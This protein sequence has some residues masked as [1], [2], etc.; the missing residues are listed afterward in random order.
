VREDFA[1]AVEIFASKT[2]VPEDKILNAIVK[3]LT[4]AYK[5]MTK[6]DNVVIELDTISKNLKIYS[7]KTVKD[8]VEDPIT[9]ISL[10]EAQKRNPDAR[11]D[12]EILDEIDPASMG[13]IAAQISQQVILEDIH[14]VEQDLIYDEFSAKLGTI[15]TG[16]Y[17]R[18][19]KKEDIIVDLAKVEGLLP[20]EKQLPK[21]RLKLGEKV[22][23]YIKNV[24]KVNNHIRIILSRTDPDFVKKLFELE[25]PELASNVVQIKGIARDPGERSKVAV[26]SEQSDIDPVGSCV[27]MKGVRI[28]SVIREL[29]GEKIDIV[30]WD[31]NTEKYIQNL[32]SPVKILNVKLNHEEKISIV[33]VPPDQ[34][35]SAIGKDG[36]N[37]RLA[38]ILLG[39]TID[40]KSEDDFQR[41]L[42]AE[43]S[44]KKIKEL[45]QEPADEEK[46]QKHKKKATTARK[47]QLKEVSA[48][49]EEEIEETSIEE[50]P[51]VPQIVI[52]K[53]Q[54]A[55]YNSIES[56]IEMAKTDF[57]K[58]PGISKKN[59]ELIISSL[60]ENVKVVEE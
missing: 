25:V 57:E 38:A 39:W 27:G 58:I 28:Q 40:I 14:Q 35:S 17:Q 36:K 37:V 4:A 42:M 26:Y 15:V 18:K 43:E 12:D 9:D 41:L 33:V 47:K 3:A 30:R 11:I 29:D 49:E 56:I 22:R 5:K 50:L 51:D 24:E 10:L 32:L 31:E 16:V 34:L 60:E 59:S 55:G 21:D 20:Y 8:A 23:V 45:F 7:K 6:H 54:A 44:R 46:E 19:T 52:K 53:L 1:E 2:G 13:R 48:A